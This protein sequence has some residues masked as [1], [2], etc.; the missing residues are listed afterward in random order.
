MRYDDD[1]DDDDDYD[2]LF[3]LMMQYTHAV[4]MGH[5]WKPGA[6]SIAMNYVFIQCE[7]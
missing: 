4:K 6:E 3:L 7:C 1:D 5:R 2:N